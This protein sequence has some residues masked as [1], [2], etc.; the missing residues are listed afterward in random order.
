MEFRT[1]KFVKPGDLN[2][3]NKLFGGQLLAWIDEECYIYAA[4]QLETKQLVTKIIGEVDFKAPAEQGDV[5]E[6]GVE[7]VSVG[8]TSIMLRCEVRNKNT[9]KT[10]C[11]IAKVVF[12]HVDENGPAPH[13]KGRSD[14]HHQVVS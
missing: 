1:R 9:K 6:I 4:C 5:I 10:I 13:G 7:T 14:D 2:P 8:T 12:V 3:S 11:K